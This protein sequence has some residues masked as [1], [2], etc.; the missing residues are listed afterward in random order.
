MGEW[1]L[2][3]LFQVGD[4][5]SIMSES[6]FGVYYSMVPFVMDCGVTSS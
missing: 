6:I 1:K 4:T 5:Y 2:W 3:V